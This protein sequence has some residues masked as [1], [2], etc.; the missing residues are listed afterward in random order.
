M[1]NMGW[2]KLLQSS[3]LQLY[4]VQSINLNFFV[5]KT[6][7]RK[8]PFWIY[9]SGLWEIVTG[10]FDSYTVG[11]VGNKKECYLV[12]PREWYSLTGERKYIMF[13]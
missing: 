6:Y 12:S 5:L 1:T 3:D 7:G 11:F 9:Y 13:D 4:L 2:F 10:S 8:N